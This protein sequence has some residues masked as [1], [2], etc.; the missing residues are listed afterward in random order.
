MG[1]PPSFSTIGNMA[2]RKVRFVPP[3]KP[4]F[5]SPG[6][7]SG[8]PIR[9]GMK[10][11]PEYVGEMVRTVRERLGLSRIELADRLTV[12][13]E[14]VKKMETGERVK[15]W[16]KLAEVAEALETT[17]NELLGFPVVDPESLGSALQPILKAFGHD[18]EDAESIARILLEAVED[19]QSLQGSEP[20]ALRYRHAGE[21]AAAR[22]RRRKTS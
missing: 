19:G 5:V 15:Q 20:A 8:A 4:H 1:Q 6:I 21:I 7:G 2:D 11:T 22:F 17:P 16:L 14:T 10:R 12:S 18:P 3:V 13:E 9:Y